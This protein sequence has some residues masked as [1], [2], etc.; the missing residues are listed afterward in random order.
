M[1]AA[2][3]TPTNAER[4]RLWEAE[5]PGELRRAADEWAALGYRE[6]SEYLRAWARGEKP[7][8]IVARPF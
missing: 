1:A 5:D 7:A 6:Y 2:V 4:A 3:S 8:A